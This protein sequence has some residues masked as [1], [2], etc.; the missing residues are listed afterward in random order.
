MVGTNISRK[1]YLGV[2]HKLQKFIEF[3]KII[4]KGNQLMS[5]LMLLI[6][7]Q[8]MFIYCENQKI[9]IYFFIWQSRK[10]DGYVR[11]LDAIIEILCN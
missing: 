3:K 10:P 4:D 11:M 7:D 5:W 6:D 1:N 9:L 8:S 2:N